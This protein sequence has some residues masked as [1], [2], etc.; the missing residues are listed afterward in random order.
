MIQRSTC[1]CTRSR[2]PTLH[3]TCVRLCHPCPTLIVPT[4]STDWWIPSQGRLL[5]PSAQGELEQH[6]LSQPRLRPLLRPPLSHL[7]Q[8][9]H[10]L[11]S[12]LSFASQRHPP[13]TRPLPTA[14]S[15]L[16][17]RLRLPSFPIQ[18]P[19]VDL[20]DPQRW[21]TQLCQV[22]NDRPLFVHLVPLDP[23]LVLRRVEPRPA[24][25]NEA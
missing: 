20:Q 21:T 11:S 3:S 12:R 4:P 2:S 1:R 10:P 15:V 14:S 18:T 7:H 8:T 24:R 6:L 25:S 22:R 19:L 5:H 9:P 17:L 13:P 23:H 16:R